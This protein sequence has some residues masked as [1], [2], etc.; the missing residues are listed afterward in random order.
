MIFLEFTPEFTAEDAEERRVENRV[1]YFPLRPSASS[2]V[3]LI[4]PP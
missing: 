1:G 3:K 2:A 4:T